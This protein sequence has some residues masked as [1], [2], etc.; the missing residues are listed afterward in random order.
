TPNGAAGL[1]YPVQVMTMTNLDAIVEWRPVDFA[2]VGPLE[3]GL[4]VTGFVAL[5]R[6]VR[7]PPFRAALLLLLLFLALRHGP[8]ELVLAFVAPLLLAEPVGRAFGRAAAE[9]RLALAAYAILAIWG[10]GIIG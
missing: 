9:R 6:G 3:L 5:W 7:V 1:V 10:A 4:L 8:H 2:R